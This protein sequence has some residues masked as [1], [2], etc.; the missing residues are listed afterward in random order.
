MRDINNFLEDKSVRKKGINF[1]K[2]TKYKSRRVQSLNENDFQYF[3]YHDNFKTKS[4]IKSL[5]KKN[6]LGTEKMTKKKI[7]SNILNTRANC[8][9][10]NEGDIIIGNSS[11][12]SIGLIKSR[13]FLKKSGNFFDSGHTY[14]MKSKIENISSEKQIFMF[15]DEYSNFEKKKNLGNLQN[16]KQ[17]SRF[18]G[19]HLSSHQT[20]QKRLKNNSRKSKIKKKKNV[21]K[22]VKSASK[23]RNKSKSDRKRNKKDSSNSMK[24]KSKKANLKAEDKKD[25]SQT[26]IPFEDR[27]FGGNNLAENDEII[28]IDVLKND[29]ED[30]KRK[31]NCENCIC[32]VNQAVLDLRN[33]L[34]KRSNLL[35]RIETYN[36][37]SYTDVGTNIFIMN[38]PMDALG[39]LRRDLEETR[40]LKYIGSEK[41][42]EVLKRGIVDI[43]GNGNYTNLHCL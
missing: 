40:G 14:N 5:E 23:N 11:E 20:A 16:Q 7:S 32:D 43:S 31:E 9:F 27:T 15:T 39:Q 29:K 42:E 8:Q 41:V 6:K 13:S 2:I 1:G 30:T 37:N 4:V 22:K 17:H 25:Q 35:D 26:I 28:S 33:M 34:V 10:A 18:I 24:Q 19:R 36:C 38:G 21:K 12:C 3:N